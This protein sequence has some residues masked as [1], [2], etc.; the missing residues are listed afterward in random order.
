MENRI[1]RVC[2]IARVARLSGGGSFF[3]PAS[4]SGFFSFPIITLSRAAGAL[5]Q[6]TGKTTLAVADGDP[7][8]VIRCTFTGVEF[9]RIT[10]DTFRATLKVTGGKSYLDFNGSNGYTFSGPNPVQGSYH[11]GYR[12]ANVGA[13]QVG[14]CGAANSFKGKLV[15]AAAKAL[16]GKEAVAN[17]T[18]TATTAQVVGTDYTIGF[19]YGATGD[20]RYFHNGADDGQG[21]ADITTQ[22]PSGSESRIGI[23]ASGLEKIVARIYGWGIYSQK[24]T[25]ADIAR[26]HAFLRTFFP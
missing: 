17:W 22:A 19:N 26:I 4:L 2:R 7:V 21:V 20:G 6:D 14:I 5:W 9:T 18:N 25:A 24:Q 13:A 8:A 10:D 3:N 11:F 16:G 23:N 15:D 1:N 12:P